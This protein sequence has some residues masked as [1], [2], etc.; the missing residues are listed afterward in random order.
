[1]NQKGIIAE[2]AD[3]FFIG[4]CF[5]IEN[6]GEFLPFDK[7][8]FSRMLRQKFLAM[9]LEKLDFSTQFRY[10]LHVDF[11]QKECITRHVRCQDI[12]WFFNGISDAP[13]QI[14]DLVFRSKTG[15]PAAMPFAF[16]SHQGLIAPLWRRWP[17][18]FDVPS[19]CVGAG[20]PDAVDGLIGAYR[21]HLGQTYG[22]SLVG[23]VFLCVPLGLVLWFAL[24]AAARRLRP[25]SKS[26]FF[27][28]SWNMGLEAFAE[29]IGPPDFK[30]RWWRVVWCLGLGAF[31]HLF[32][33]L[34]SHGGF[35]WL[36]PW[37]PKIRIFPDWW[38]ITWARLPVPGYEKA[39]DVGPHLTV[40]IFLS[41]LGIYLLFRPA[42][43]SSR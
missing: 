17:G 19:L 2:K 5:R 32:F 42:F 29:G 15:R 20:M 40:W 7:C 8:E 16:P 4:V 18:V 21:G 35:P 12:E 37:V 43:K 36:M 24:H 41:A 13:K 1:M 10:R 23:M 11:L 9:R 34:I 14:V 25:V 39:Y 33:D 6:T 30:R 27:A 38:Y 22:H 26:G 28:R 3:A 31:S